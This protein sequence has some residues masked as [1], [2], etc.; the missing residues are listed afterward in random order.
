MSLKIYNNENKKWEKISSLLSSSI[1]VLDAEGKYNSE[2]VE[3]CLNEIATDISTMKNDIKYIYE[4]G[5]IGGGSGGGGGSSVPTIKID[6]EIDEQGIH[7]RVV[8]S[9]EVVTIY[10]FFNS[11]NAGAGTVELSYGSQ[12]IK[13]T[14]KQGRNKWVVGKL[15]RGTHSLSI[16]VEDRQGF[17]SDPARIKIISGALEIVSDFSDAVD[18]NLNDNIR[19]PYRVYTEI[20]DAITAELTLDGVTTEKVI[21]KGDN[22]WEIGSL[23]TLGVHTASIRTYCET[24]V[25]NTLNFKLVVADSDS[26][27][28]STSF[29][30]RTFPQGKRLQI[31]YRI[32]MK[33]QYQFKSQLWLDGNLMETVSN[34][35]GVSYW[36]L[37]SELSLGIHTI[38]V[39]SMTLDEVY[40]DSLELEV[41]IVESGLIQIP[42]PVNGLIAKFDANGKMNSAQ[43]KNIWEDKSGNNVSCTLHNFNYA[44]NGWISDEELDTMTLKFAGKTYA[45]IDLAPF[46]NGIE[47]GLTFDIMFKVENTGNMD[48]RVVDC[49]NPIS[50]FQGFMID[51]EKAI[52]SGKQTVKTYHQE[53]TWTRQTFVIDRVER[54][55]RTY[56]NA[57]ISN[58]SLIG[59]REPDNDEFKF[60][61]KIILGGRRDSDGS[62]TDNST[63][64]IKTIRVYNRALTSEEILNVHMSDIKNADELSK[65]YELNYGE[66]AIPTMTITGVGIESLEPDQDSVTVKVDYIDPSNPHKRFTRDLCQLAIQGT[67][68]KYYPVKNYTLWLRENDGQPKR[69][70]APLDS[71][72]PEERWTLK[73]NYMDSSHANNVGLNKFIHELFKE[74]PYP[75]QQMNPSTRSNI[76]GQPIKVIINGQDCGVYTWNIDRYAHNNYGLVTYN[77]DGTVN[78]HNSALSYEIAV[79][80]TTGAGAFNDDSWDSIKSEFKHRYNYRGDDVTVKEGNDTVLA[81]GKHTELV[82]LIS[83][84][85][86]CTND[87][88]FADVSKHFSLPHLIDY[89]LV[90]YAFGMIDSLGKNMVITTFGRNEAGHMIWYPSF[91]DCDSVLGLANNGEIR[92]DA[93]VDMSNDAFNTKNSALWTKLKANFAQ[94]IKDRY[95]ELR[96]ER[97]LDGEIHPPIFSAE[98]VM[99]YLDGEVISKI[100]QKDYNTDAERKY[101]NSE[102][103]TWLISCNGTRKEFTRRWLEERF[104]YLDSVYEFGDFN[105][106]TMVLRTHVLG[107][108]EVRLK[109]YSPMWVRINYTSSKSDKVYVSKDRYYSFKVNLDN[110][111]ENDFTIFGASN[112]MYVDGIKDLNVSHVSISGAE[113]LIELDVSGSEHIKGL[114][115]GQNKY[116]QKVVCNNCKKLG[117][118]EKDRSIDLSG[119]KNLK[120][121]DCSS[122]NANN[123]TKIET[124]LL[125]AKGGVIEHLN[126]TNT[127]L[128]TFTIEGQE[129]LEELGLASCSQLDSLSAKNCNGLKIINMPNTKL[130]TCIIEGCENIEEI[131]LSNTKYLATLNLQGCPNLKKLNISGVLSTRIT[132]LDLTASLKLEDLDISSTAYISNITFGQYRGENG[133]LKN[134]DRLKRFNCKNSGI[135]SIR[136]GKNNPIPT[137]LDLK[138]FNLDYVTFESCPNVKEIKNINLVATSSMSPFSGCINL[139]TIQGNVSLTGSITKAFYNCGKLKN[140]HNTLNLNLSNVTSTSET[141]SS[142]KAFTWDEVKF[143]LSKMSNKYTGGW[144]TFSTCTGLT[145]S[146]PTG[147]FSKCT[148][149]KDFHEYFIDCTGITGQLPSDLFDGLTVLNNCEEMFKGT[150]ISGGVPDNLF[151]Y[152]Y[153][154]LTNT[155]Y[156]FANTK[157][158]IPP[159]NELFKWNRNIKNVQGMFSGCSQLTG[160]IPNGLFEGR[161]ELENISYF[162]N[163]C[164]NIYGEIPRGLFK[165]TSQGVSSKIK[166][167]QYFFRGTGCYGEIPKY[168]NESNKGIFDDMPLLENAQYFFPVG[169][170]GEIPKDL[171]KHNPKLLRVS[172]LFDGCTAIYGEIPSNLFKNNPNLQLA[173]KLFKNC[174][175]IDSAIPKGLFD[176][177]TQLTDVAEMFYGCTGLKG[178]IPERISE[179]FERPSEFDPEVMEKYEVVHEYGLFDN[180]NVLS[181]VSGLFHGCSNLNS[182][183]PSTLFISGQNILDMSYIFYKCWSLYGAIPEELFSN[184]RK[185]INLNSSF[186]DCRKLGKSSLEITEDDPYALPPKLFASCRELTT[187]SNAFSMWGQDVPVSG[188]TLRGSLPAT[189]FRNNSKLKDI[190]TIFSGCNLITG[191]LSGDFFIGNTEINN[192]ENAFWSTQF[193]YVGFN[194]LKTNKKINN[195]KAMFRGNNK[196]S[197][198]APKLWET[199]A[200][201][202]AE[203][204]MGCT[205]DDQ[206][207]IPSTYK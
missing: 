179:W 106:K 116:L 98:N 32:S 82:E 150:N 25:S 109:T 52:L 37:G 21:N 50:P 29:N 148:G 144:R 74:N 73:T 34:P 68:S 155:A 102:G 72:M 135:V 36:D 84:V 100:G 78:R 143:I 65:I 119:C 141:F 126:L 136:H 71:W 162:F 92:Y 1:K 83:W 12:V 62:I 5:T 44:T 86:N 123:P 81:N 180:C 160:E 167:L 114:A 132:D 115:L 96:R 157:L 182:T 18:F 147:L 35:S 15:P 186:T 61:G 166:S 22:V 196:V 19:I 103:A 137:Y 89:Y 80:S 17:T 185:V 198:N 168:I 67:T 154:F 194:L 63:C 177:N 88:F 163:N 142:C 20:P 152:P 105:S 41:E 173:D 14:I 94:Q 108:V 76:D 91:Y 149:V 170:S 127:N 27:F 70:Y 55:I 87:E 169:V 31:D 9:D 40:K 48:A 176:N 54:T 75:Q 146:V 129:Y 204:F 95:V 11:P 10:Y 205:F 187:M 60:N 26:L 38:K 56:T 118:D 90:V 110:G 64:S 159:T 2:N 66:V 201:N 85:K 153:S 42:E 101:I 79:N 171:F 46:L 124:V 178:Q 113:K 112:L 120:Y 133:E 28:V 121:F 188:N 13:E 23:G 59:E 139:E 190:S 77:E 140:I 183:I 164:P 3:G 172:G 195:I 104:V 192:C 156:M 138:G 30:E 189:L 175:G 122:S 203:C 6:G 145:G 181:T 131:N 43:N 39:V 97:N 202:T 130:S 4:N 117:E 45:E 174:T 184:C 49:R 93:G 58:A 47:T 8:K 7:T 161:A 134:Y 57:V 197:G 16:V 51:T 207:S 111:T 199:P 151:R 206:E 125:P 69:D 107:D 165:N 128:T 191:E 33:N 99:K 158:E 53:N 24:A 200:V 193:T